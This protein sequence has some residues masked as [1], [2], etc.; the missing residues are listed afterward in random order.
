V[1]L[2]PQLCGL[3]A[4]TTSWQKQTVG[5]SFMFQPGQR[6]AVL[7]SVGSGTSLATITSYVQGK[8]FQV[9]YSCEPPKGCTRDTYNVDTWLA[10]ITASARSGERWVYAEGNFT[11]KSP[12]TVDVTDSF[13]K[14]LVVTY[15]IADV[16][17]AVTTDAPDT[18][19]PSIANP[20]TFPVAQPTTPTT[21]PSSAAPIAAAVAGAAITA[22]V[23]WWLLA[24]YR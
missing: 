5:S 4:T 3:G 20:T 12:W 7:A 15:S 1:R 9:T 23:G 19:A 10:G 8:G 17:L 6:Y 11:A 2:N 13:P 21:P 16:F 22:G 24:R 14:T 18:P